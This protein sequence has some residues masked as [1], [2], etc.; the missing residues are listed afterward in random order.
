MFH[1]HTSPLYPAMSRSVALVQLLRQNQARRLNT[2][3]HDLIQ[4]RVIPVAEKIAA[5][6]LESQKSMDG[7]WGLL[8]SN[9]E[10]LRMQSSFLLISPLWTRSSPGRRAYTR[11]LLDCQYLIS[12]DVA[13]DAPLGGKDRIWITQTAYAIGNIRRAYI[14]G[15]F[16]I[17][18][19]RFS[20]INAVA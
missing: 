18:V 9:C 17:P 19:P 15:A 3:P 16:H 8:D 4:S 12:A 13:E 11:R 10:E 2:L 7:S 14:I 6:I 1:K 5:L 20:G